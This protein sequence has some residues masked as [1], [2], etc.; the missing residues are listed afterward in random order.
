MYYD[1]DKRDKT[2]LPHDPLKAIIAPRPIGWVSTMNKKGEINLAPYSFFNA[3]SSKPMILGFSSEGLK[4]S[5]TF[6]E[7]GRE[8]VWNMASL[9]LLHAMN[10]SSAPYPRGLNEFGPA[11]LKMAASNLVRPPRV[12]ESPAALE[13]VVTNIIHLKDRHGE[14]IGSYLVLGEVVGVH[15]ADQFIH[16]GRVDTAAMLP[17]ARLGYMD[18]AVVDKVFQLQ[19]PEGGGDQV[20]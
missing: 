20:P 3:F 13:C 9:P 14:E 8:F 6:A 10:T 16:A 19:R 2:L 11:K 18:Y 4:D 7:D 17:L 1:A 15:I 12:S 5:V